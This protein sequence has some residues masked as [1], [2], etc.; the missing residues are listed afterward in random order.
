MYSLPLQ[1]PR[2]APEGIYIHILIQMHLRVLNVK[3]ARSRAYSHGLCERLQ[4][5]KSSVEF[6]CPKYNVRVCCKKHAV[7]FNWIERINAEMVINI[8]RTTSR[9]MIIKALKRD[10]PES[11]GVK[12]P[13]QNALYDPDKLIPCMPQYLDDLSDMLECNTGLI[14]TDLDLTLD[15]AIFTST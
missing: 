15:S 6:V 10:L 9:R 11:N 12:F 5:K 3:H 7:K 2:N 4:N 14:A 8:G 1:L 13:P